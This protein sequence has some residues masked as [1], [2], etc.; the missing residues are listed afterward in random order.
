MIKDYYDK[1]EE[2]GSHFMGKNILEQILN[3]PD[4]IG[5]K[6]FKAINENGVNTYVVTGVNQQGELM[7]ESAVVNPQGQI[8]ISEGIVADRFKIEGW[9]ESTKR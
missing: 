3:Q 2:A 4:C 1:Y 5:I 7:M 6:I 8:Q 9:F